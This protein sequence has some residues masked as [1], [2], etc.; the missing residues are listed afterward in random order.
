MYLLHSSYS[1]Q[2]IAPFI[3]AAKEL[4]VLF[5][6]LQIAR[7]RPSMRIN[8][9]DQYHLQAMFFQPRYQSRYLNNYSNKPLR[10]QFYSKTTFSSD[11]RN[12]PL[13]FKILDHLLKCTKANS[14][15]SK[16]DSECNHIHCSIPCYHLQVL[17][18]CHSH[19][20]HIPAEMLVDSLRIAC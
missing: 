17:A 3:H 9:R 12:P 16:S 11:S 7:L 2:L 1:I 4:K 5:K 19:H 8:S 18:L 15:I 6:A 13:W 10:V 20:H 14:K